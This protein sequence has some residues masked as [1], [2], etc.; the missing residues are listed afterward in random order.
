MESRSA[1]LDLW[2]LKRKHSLL[3]ESQGCE[4][5]CQEGG[6]GGGVE[7]G[8]QGWAGVTHTGRPQTGPWGEREREQGPVDPL[9]WN[10]CGRARW[11]RPALHVSASERTQKGP[12]GD[13][14]AGAGAAGHLTATVWI[15]LGPPA[16][17]YLNN[18]EGKAVE[19][20]LQES[21]QC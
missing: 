17:S 10:T 3:R 12:R 13:L 16:D 14:C 9:M 19:H 5:Q 4:P 7:H 15:P 6:T 2:P 11:E 18:E 1:G 20:D 8:L 21:P